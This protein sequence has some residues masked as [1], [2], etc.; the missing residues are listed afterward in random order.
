MLTLKTL[1]GAGWSVAAR[2]L[3]RVI[4][5]ATLLLLARLLTPAD[6]GLTAIAVSL[7]AIVEMVLEV[8]LVQALMRLQKIETSHLDTA[9]TLGL[10]RG[11]V[12]AILMMLAA[13]PMAHIYD[14]SRLVLL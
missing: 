11:G 12:I 3:A 1:R 7:V 10:L 6:F 9:F 13:W 4:D 8:P 14:D 5:L 2:T